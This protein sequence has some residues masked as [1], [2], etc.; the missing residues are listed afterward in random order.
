LIEIRLELNVDEAF[1]GL[2]LYAGAFLD[3]L[4]ESRDAEELLCWE[5]DFRRPSLVPITDPLMTRL[6]EIEVPV[7]DDPERL[8]PEEPGL[9]L[10]GGGGGAFSDL[11]DEMVA[12]GIGSGHVPVPLEEL[13]EDFRMLF[14]ILADFRLFDEWL[15]RTI[16]PRASFSSL[17]SLGGGG[18]DLK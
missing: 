9:N 4:V 16:T 18:G 5:V 7:G 10:G 8:F 12:K 6:P 17:E 11:R 13:D 1:F 14:R 2:D 15:F 3:L